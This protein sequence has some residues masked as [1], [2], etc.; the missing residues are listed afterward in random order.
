MAADF[1]LL[2]FCMHIEG[3]KKMVKALGRLVSDVEV[4][5]VIINGN[6][7]SV[8]NNSFAMKNSSN[9]KDDST[10]ID[11]TAW[12]GTADLIG[13]YLQKGDEILIT[14]ELRNKGI[15]VDDKK[16]TVVYLLVRQIE[17]TN[18]NKRRDA[19]DN[20]TKA[21]D[22]SDVPFADLDEEE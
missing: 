21:P 1:R 18:G 15:T 16:R 9:K 2:L 20:V 6:S 14:G 12:D 8:L 5:K 19:A 3:V 17:F 22:D 7:K 10:F 4:K 13:K 11:I